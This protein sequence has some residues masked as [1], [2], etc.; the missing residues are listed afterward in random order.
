[1]QG[2]G[3]IPGRIMRFGTFFIAIVFIF[4]LIMM[5]IPL[6]QSLLSVLLVIN[7]A[8]S[9]IVLLITVYA[10]HP[11]DLSVFPS[12]LLVI[13]LYRL[14]LNV[15]STRLILSEANA[16][17][18]IE[19][20]G[21]FVVR[22]NYIVGFV[23][24]IILVVIQYVVITRG[25]QRVAEVAARF[26]LDGMPARQMS[27]DADLNVGIITEEQAR[28]K[29][30]RI[31]READF[32]GAMDGASKFVQGDAI[33]A[34]I[35]T[36]VNIIGGLAVG[37]LQKGMDITEA[38]A[39]YTQLTV[40]DG[41][42]SQ[43]PA[44]IVSTAAGIL[45]TRTESEFDL[46]QDMARQ[47]L[48]QPRAL[49][50]VAIT[51]FLFGL[52]PA[53]PTIPFFLLGITIGV[54]AWFVQTSAR[55]TSAEEE[56]MAEL[57]K[58]QEASLETLGATQP[59]ILLVE[60]GLDLI[61]LVDQNQGGDL[62]DRVPIVKTR[63]AKELGFIVPTV[64]IVDNSQLG[65]NYQISIKGT[66]IAKGTLMPDRLLAM[67]SGDVERQ[68]R[69]IETQEPAFGIPSFWIPET[70]RPFAESAG[71]TVVT[72]S[73]A[74]ATHLEETIKQ[75]ADELLGLQQLQELLDNLK[76]TNPTVVSEVV[77]EPLPLIDL[78][79]VLRG[80]L[81]ERVPIR[82]LP[83]IL[84]TLADYSRTDR[85]YTSNKDV[86]FLIENVRQALKGELMQQHAPE[87]E[88]SVL[89]FAPDLHNTFS[90]SFRDDGGVVTFSPDAKMARQIIDGI[91][92]N[93]EAVLKGIEPV[94]LCS[95]EIRPF[96]RQLIQR[97]FPTL[98]VLSHE[99][100]TPNVKVESVGV[101]GAE[102]QEQNPQMPNEV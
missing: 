49:W 98:A 69:G 45:V 83:T 12:L 89:V 54:L 15:A 33:A 85:L 81:A 28:E 48:S 87:G 79:K 56:E 66:P 44:L 67:S 24:F 51:L 29:R 2:G 27:V 101:I 13:T 78:H 76:Q 1:M 52:V 77:P 96:V 92:E 3:Q 93:I 38:L 50:I 11:L 57:E 94:I 99:E 40:G 16:G 65:S 9:L 68:I 91:S 14:S 32:Y 86:T 55:R 97:Q 80:L 84:E 47:L 73:T 88:L 82:N 19:A 30:Q 42:V 23:I 6:P 39:T 61:P 35:I 64:R 21:T 53:L 60:L 8:G 102:T 95:S 74:L 4:V 34:I 90:T 75:H 20:F 31:Q 100:V 25:A 72:P 70:E 7:I 18:V 71:Y 58:E 36:I 37:I 62:L 41:L 10:T 46:G 26:T 22:G 63:C 59:D 5:I 17:R 43:I